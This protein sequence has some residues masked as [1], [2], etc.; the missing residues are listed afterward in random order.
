MVEVGD[1]APTFTLVG[2][3]DDGMHQYSL[4]EYTAQ[5]PV[6]LSFY[7][8]DFSPDCTDQMCSIDDVGLLEFEDDLTVLGISQDG[9][10]SHMEFADANDIGY[11]LLCDTA[12]EV[13]EAYGVLNE[14]MEGLSRVAQRSLF[15]VGEDGRV[16]YRWVAD[17]NR[18]DWTVEPVDE[19]KAELD[20]LR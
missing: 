7:V 2:V 14:E 6:V 4:G 9:P 15:L 18:D 11:P 19:L 17:H 13:A 10:Y 12:Q 16:H 1:T 3:D 20:R 5:G 8:Y